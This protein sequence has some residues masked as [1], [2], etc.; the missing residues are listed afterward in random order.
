MATIFTGTKM[1]FAEMIAMDLGDYF[2]DTI[3]KAVEIQ[4]NGEKRIGIIIREEGG[5]EA[6]APILYIDEFYNKVT[7]GSMDYEDALETIADGISDHGIN[8]QNTVVEALFEGLKEKEKV[9]KSFVPRLVNKTWCTG[10]MG[11]D[12][13]YKPFIEDMMIMLT[14]DTE[15]LC[16]ISD[17]N[18]KVSKKLLK[19]LKL[20]ISVEELFRIAIYNIEADVFFEKAN[21]VAEEMG[22]PA[23][24][25]E[26]LDGGFLRFKGEKFAGATAILTEK[27]QKYLKKMGTA[28]LMPVS[29]QE[30]LV[31]PVERK[32]IGDEDFIESNYEMF[33]FL[34]DG[35]P[36]EQFLS[37]NVYFFDG[38]KI[39][40]L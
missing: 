33:E 25:V 39:N 6:I 35:M 3:A 14:I 21:K 9:I 12:L 28:I 38:E 19:E 36:E 34:S 22:V 5:K 13:I 40:L 8:A 16:G 27:A 20:H 37:K 23:K 15:K 10:P 26:K 4:R 7:N 1:A 32:H 24:V 18:I 29:I 11:D 31:I 2:S 30:W 17:G